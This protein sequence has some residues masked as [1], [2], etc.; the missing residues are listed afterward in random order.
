M[1]VSLVHNLLLIFAGGGE[2]LRGG[3]GVGGSDEFDTFP[4][5]LQRV[6]NEIRTKK[7]F[8]KIPFNPPPRGFLVPTLLISPAI[9]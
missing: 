2:E 8:L 5:G 7:N 6:R 3:G 1:F 9:Y 4:I